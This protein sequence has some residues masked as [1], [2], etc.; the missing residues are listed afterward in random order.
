MMPILRAAKQSFEPARSLKDGGRGASPDRPCGVLTA[1]LKARRDA[2]LRV[3]PHHFRL[4]SS[5]AGTDHQPAER[6]SPARPVSPAFRWRCARS[7][8]STRFR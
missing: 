3:H 7:A 8:F 5:G 4:E 1:A 2:R 6:T